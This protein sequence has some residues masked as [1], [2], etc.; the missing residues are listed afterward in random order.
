MA[1]QADITVKKYDGTTDIVYNALSPSGGDNT[2][3]QWRVNAAGAVASNKPFFTVSAKYTA[4]KRARIVTCKLIMP[5]TYT[6][7]TT[8]IVSIRNRV[9]STFTH[10]VPLEIA[11]VTGQE[12]GAQMANLLKSPLIQTTLQTGFAPT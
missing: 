11:D 4:D 9:S 12:A 6:D 5:E 2:P 8:G 7:T 10:I 3:A 1:Q